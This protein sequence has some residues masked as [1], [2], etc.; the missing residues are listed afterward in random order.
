MRAE[1][2][3]GRETGSV[4][5]QVIGPVRAAS[6]RMAAPL[7]PPL[8]RCLLAR[9]AVDCPKAVSYDGL[10]DSIWGERSPVNVVKSIQRYVWA[11]RRV[12]GHR[13]IESH[14]RSYCL[15]IEPIAID[16]VRF[17]I[18][19]EQALSTADRPTRLDRLSRVLDRYRGEPLAGLEAPFIHAVRIEI[20]ELRWAVRDDRCRTAHAMGRYELVIAD[21]LPGVDDCDVHPRPWPLLVS[22]LDRVGRRHDALKACR[23]ILD[24]YG[25]SGLQAVPEL[26]E[27]ERELLTA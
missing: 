8:Q 27:M 7:G 17:R 20:D 1:S 25:T 2:S 18:E 14:G 15:G 16:L 4:V 22:A 13:A 23:T 6:E 19:V 11:L 24:R 9:L 26:V 10:V 12:L 5:V 21:L 3:V